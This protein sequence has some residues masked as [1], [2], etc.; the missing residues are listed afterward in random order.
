MAT[1]V[2]PIPVGPQITIILG[3]AVSDFMGQQRLRWPVEPV[4]I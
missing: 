3:F 1:V 4:K 2:L